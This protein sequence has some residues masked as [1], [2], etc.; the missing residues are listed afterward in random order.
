[1][2]SPY[3]DQAGPDPQ[4]AMIAQRLALTLNQFILD[5]SMT[6]AA[7]YSQIFRPDVVFIAAIAGA[8][9]SKRGPAMMNGQMFGALAAFAA[10][11]TPAAHSIVRPAPV[12]RI[13]AF[14]IHSQAETP[15]WALDPGQ[16]LGRD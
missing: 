14:S 1:M 15:E 2:I 4:R 6:S 11:T 13:S 12:P 9:I 16:F 3:H 8:T 10:V 5:Q 7:Q